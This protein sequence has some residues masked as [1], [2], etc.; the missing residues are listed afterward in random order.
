MFCEILDKM[1]VITRITVAMLVKIGSANLLLLSMWLV[2]Q[3]FRRA[4]DRSIVV[5]AYLF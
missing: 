4:Y 2:F 5:G 3:L 1:R